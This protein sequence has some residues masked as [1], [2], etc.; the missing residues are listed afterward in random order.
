MLKFLKFLVFLVIMA[1]LIKGLFVFF[2][3]D[4]FKVVNVKVEGENEL[5]KSD[6]TEKILYI[7]NKENL[8]YLNTKKM[9]KYLEEDV[10]IKNI[11]IKKVYPSEL[12]VKIEEN[13][14][15][16][17]LRQGNNFYIINDE[18][19]IFAYIDE[20]SNKNLPIIDA[21]DKDDLEDI[22]QVLSNIKNENFFSNISE[23]KKVK[24]DY[25][26][27]LNDGTLI[28]TSI[29]VNHTKYE[30]CFKLYQS[31]I[32]ENKKV[33]YI[34]LRFKDINLK[35]RDLSQTNL[36]GKDGRDPK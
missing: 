9:E 20:V 24:S 13:K 35:E 31:L 33:E 22:L 2:S 32:S 29:V 28:K 23:I 10:R 34:D 18:G 25:E 16:S 26:I 5:I 6:I 7:K 11:E 14:P 15:Y 8:I 17:Y 12:I 21:A 30:N 36:E 1:I 3:K 27:L 19:K 4:F